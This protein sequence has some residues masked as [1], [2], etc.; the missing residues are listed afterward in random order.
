[1][2]GQ[3][4]AYRIV[5]PGWGDLEGVVDRGGHAIAWSNGTTWTR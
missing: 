1:L 3:N 4:A 5:V 2:G